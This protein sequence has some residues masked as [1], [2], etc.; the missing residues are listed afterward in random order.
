MSRR[1]S[2]YLSARR[3]REEVKDR[4]DN[5]VEGRALILIPGHNAGRIAR[6]SGLL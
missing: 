6:S 3:V 1:R 4:I 5:G 2:F